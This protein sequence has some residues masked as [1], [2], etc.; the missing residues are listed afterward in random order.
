MDRDRE[1]DMKKKIPV[2]TFC[3]MLYAPCFSASAQQPEH[4]KNTTNK[5]IFTFSPFLRG[6]L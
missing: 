6:P 1:K 2:L 5:L 4:N 3:V